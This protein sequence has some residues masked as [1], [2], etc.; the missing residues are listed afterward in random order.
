MTSQP[1][2]PLAPS[3]PLPNPDVL[4]FEKTYA[5]VPHLL[6]AYRSAIDLERH[7]E[8]HKDKQVVVRA[9]VLGYLLLH[10]PTH[11]AQSEMAKAI[12]TCANDTD[13]LC[14]LADAF[15]KAFILT[16][17]K[18][19]ERTP[20]ISISERSPPSL[21]AKELLQAP[22]S[23]AEAKERALLRDQYRYMVTGTYD[24]S[25]PVPGLQDGIYTECA[26]II[27]ESTYF[28]V[29]QSGCVPNSNE[30]VKDQENVYRIIKTRPQFQPTFCSAVIELT[31][32]DPLRL[33][34]PSPH[35]LAFHAACAKVAHL[36]GAT[37][38]IDKYHREAERLCVLDPDGGSSDLLVHL[39]QQVRVKDVL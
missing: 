12:Y 5:R 1:Y 18:T 20:M 35:L 38:V 14:Q 37:E 36:S 39:L 33:P 29:E 17:K 28:G 15:V 23:H 10:L 30:D 13:E 19:S 7:G 4:D 16:F 31:T 32:P 21:D 26:H 25:A 9:R 8:E 2:I 11:D 22:R 34:L 3:S 24:L 27:P 6:S